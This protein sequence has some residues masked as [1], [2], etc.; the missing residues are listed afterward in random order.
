MHLTEGKIEV[1]IFFCLFDSENQFI[2]WLQVCKSICILYYSKLNESNMLSPVSTLQYDWR[3]DED[4]YIFKNCLEWNYCLR[5]QYNSNIKLIS[6][7]NTHT[8]L[9]R[10][11]N[12]FICSK[13]KQI[14]IFKIN[15]LNIKLPNLSYVVKLFVLTHLCYDL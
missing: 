3:N 13:I 15:L 8:Y 6:L 5:S 14:Q 4:S 7:L 9:K 10:H 2:G 12:I 11:G 1:R